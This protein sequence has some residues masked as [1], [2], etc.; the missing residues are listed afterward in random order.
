MKHSILLFSAALLLGMSLA[1]PAHPKNAEAVMDR[2]WLMDADGDKKISEEEAQGQLKDNFG[3]VDADGDGFVV[4]SELD[5][6]SKRLLGGDA[7]A[8]REPSGQ[9][10]QN[11]GR[12]AARAGSR[13]GDGAAQPRLPRRE[14]GMEA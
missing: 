8:R 13:G 7:R 10:A 1:T 5:A 11:D 4:Q 3:R 12:S 2:W 6:L 9:Y 14:R